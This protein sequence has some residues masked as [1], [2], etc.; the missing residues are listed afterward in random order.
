MVLELDEGW[1]VSNSP[2]RGVR[3]TIHNTHPDVR[4]T[5]TEASR[6]SLMQALAGTHIRQV[7]VSVSRP[8][9]LRGMHVHHRQVDA[10][11]IASGIAQVAV[12]DTRPDRDGKFISEMRV[13][14]PGHGVVIPP[15]IGHGYLALDDV[16]LIYAVS[17]EYDHEEPDD[18]GYDAN[19]CSGWL[20]SP[21]KA[22]RSQRDTYTPSISAASQ[23]GTP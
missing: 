23:T 21:S 12:Q 9:V 13:L 6:D 1:L 17:S 3:W 11:Y 14:Y 2:V 5:M 16:V 19:D 15:G 4:G 8:N 18:F 7:N 10:W 20:I 22:I